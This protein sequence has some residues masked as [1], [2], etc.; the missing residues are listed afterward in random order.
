MVRAVKQAGGVSV[1]A[2]AGDPSRNPVLL[3]DDQ[4]GQLIDAGLDG[5]EV[6]HRGNPPQQRRR[7]L[8]IASRHHLL[9]TGG[10]DWHGQGGKPNRL[11]ENLTD[12]E[13]VRSIVER[14][15]IPLI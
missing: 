9:V 15:A 11:G 7:L 1:I 4:I 2:H 10:S 5:L 13:T 6:W 8:D 12:D 3:S 14:G